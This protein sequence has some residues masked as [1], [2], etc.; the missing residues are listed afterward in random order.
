MAAQ[1]G[2]SEEMHNK[3]SE[4]A[5][6]HLDVSCAASIADGWRVLISLTLSS[7]CGALAGQK[8]IRPEATSSLSPHSGS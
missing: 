1:S 5:T 8:A 7:L 6:T 3:W 4:E 2:F